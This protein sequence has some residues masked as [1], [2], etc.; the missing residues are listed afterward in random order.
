MNRIY[1]VSSTRLINQSCLRFQPCIPAHCKS[2]NSNIFIPGF[3]RPQFL[4]K[5]L[6]SLTCM[7]YR[8]PF[9]QPWANQEYASEKSRAQTKRMFRFY[10]F[11]S[12]MVHEYLIDDMVRFP[13]AGCRVA[14]TSTSPALYP[15]YASHVEQ[16][17]E[18][19]FPSLAL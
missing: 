19:Y 3:L 18:A 9:L 6:F 16:P 12:S 5:T 15:R 17:Q 13:C 8:L 10:A 14:P 1:K 2:V 4:D 7:F 11:P